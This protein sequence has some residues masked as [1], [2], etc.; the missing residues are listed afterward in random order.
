MI[1]ITSL[2]NLVGKVVELRFADGHAARARLVSVDL[3]APPEMIY[4]VIHVIERGPEQLAGVGP[5][6]VAAADPSLLVEVRHVA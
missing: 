4:E 3:D 1:D 2:P 6:T 5:G